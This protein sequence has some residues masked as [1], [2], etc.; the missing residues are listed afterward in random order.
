MINGRIEKFKQGFQKDIIKAIAI[1]A[2]KSESCTILAMPGAGKGDI[3]GYLTSQDF[4]ER[5]CT[6]PNTLIIDL[7]LNN[8]LEVN[9]LNFYRYLY[10]TVVQKS[11][12][13]LKPR[14][15]DI[16]WLETINSEYKTNIVLQDAF[17]IFESIKDLVT[18][19]SEHG[20]NLIL[21]LDHLPRIKSIGSTIFNNL[22]VLRNINKEQI[23]LFFIANIN[24]YNLITPEEMGNLYALVNFKKIYIPPLAE[25]YSNNVIEEFEHLYNVT[26]PT[27]LKANFHILSGGNIWYLK[28]LT[29]IYSEIGDSIFLEKLDEAQLHRINHEQ[30]MKSVNEN[31]WNKLC[32]IDQNQLLQYLQT[33]NAENLN[34]FLLNTGVLRKEGNKLVFFS[35]LFQLYLESLSINLSENTLREPQSK[36]T[37]VNKDTREVYI[38]GKQINSEFTRAEFSVISLLIEKQ[39]KVISRDDVAKAMWGEDFYDS[40][41]DYAIDRNISRIRKKLQDNASAPRYLHTIKGIGFKFST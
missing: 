14:E 4:L 37:Y 35:P 31:T 26:V 3:I 8:L 23:A 18:Q 16:D 21:I 20:Y 5:Y 19:F 39:N 29:K 22:K 33:K 32:E 36:Q 17:I 25:Q 30:E 41:S 34:D 24:L 7:D 40:Y 10:K 9:P 27:K 2:A 28:T 15:K 38:S 11:L 13:F 12:V 6:N 1:E